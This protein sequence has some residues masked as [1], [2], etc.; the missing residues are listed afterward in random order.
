[1]A[2]DWNKPKH[3]PE[4]LTKKKDQE[5]NA[6]EAGEYYAEQYG[7]GYAVL[8]STTQFTYAGH[9]LS[10]DIIFD[11]DY[12]TFFHIRSTGANPIEGGIYPAHFAEA[13]ASELISDNFTGKGGHWQILTF[14]LKDTVRK[15]KN[16]GEFGDN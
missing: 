6:K 2:Q 14:E 13:E 5:M 9:F 12:E 1:M 3:G 4:K 10:V 8:Y 15:L 11:G 7:P 16:A